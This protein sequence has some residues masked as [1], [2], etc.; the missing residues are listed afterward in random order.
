MKTQYVGVIFNNVP[1]ASIDF[2][3]NKIY[4][5]KDNIGATI[6]DEV[7]VRC[8]SGRL[9]IVEVVTVSDVAPSEKLLNG[10]SFCS[11]L[12]KV[13][14]TE[15][16]KRKQ[17][18][19]NKQRTEALYTEVIRT[20]SRNRPLKD[21]ARSFLCSNPDQNAP[22]IKEAWDKFFEA[23]RLQK[24]TEAYEE[25]YGLCASTSAK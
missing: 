8:M 12:C 21:A 25:E 4:Y 13:D 1:G 22:E 7:V 6:G 18:W 19:E 11:T 16:H 24:E 10:R 17:Y 9:A 15:E 2:K 23:E 14:K 5:F 3:E 20:T